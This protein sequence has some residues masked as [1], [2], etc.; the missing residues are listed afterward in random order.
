MTR[1]VPCPFL[2]PISSISLLASFQDL[3]RTALDQ[4]LA[5]VIIIATVRSKYI[6]VDRW[7][8]AIKNRM[9]RVCTLPFS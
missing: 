7:E 8:D 4:R 3:F 9:T 5:W 2:N 1:S 6:H